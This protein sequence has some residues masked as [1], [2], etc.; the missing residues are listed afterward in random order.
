MYVCGIDSFAARVMAVIVRLSLWGSDAPIDALGLA[1]TMLKEHDIMSPCT[2]VS[3]PRVLV[4]HARFR[5]EMAS[6]TTLGEAI[7]VPRVFGSLTSRYV[8]VTEWVE[9]VKVR[10]YPLE[11]PCCGG[12]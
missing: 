11:H 2:G 3:C 6:S 12:T 9:G 7:V 4:Y 1:K 5:T 8:L 10:C